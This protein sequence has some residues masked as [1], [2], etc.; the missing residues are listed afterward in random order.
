MMD[1]LA[2]LLFQVA[3]SEM[4]YIYPNYTSPV[5]SEGIQ[6]VCQDYVNYFFCYAFSGRGQSGYVSNMQILDFQSEDKV[7]VETSSSLLYPGDRSLY[8]MVL[9]NTTEEVYVFGGLG[10]NGIY[11]DVWSYS[12]YEDTWEEVNQVKAIER[13]YDFAYALV[14][15]S[16]VV[17]GGMG[18]SQLALNDVQV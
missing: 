16:L 3:K 6:M 7:T 9:S 17:V 8:G 5:A 18:V 15:N 12:I 1:I 11:N 14:N 4:D 13:R 10:P 2:L